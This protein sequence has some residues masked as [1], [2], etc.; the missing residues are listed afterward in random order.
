MNGTGKPERHIPVT[1]C[2]IAPIPLLCNL[3]KKYIVTVHRPY[4]A[5][6]K[7]CS[8]QFCE[9]AVRQNALKTHFVC[10]LLL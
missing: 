3:Y 7:L 6:S 2:D 10:I 1:C 8:M 5:K 9:T 4:S